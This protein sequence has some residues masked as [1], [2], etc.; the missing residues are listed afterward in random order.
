MTYFTDIEQT[1]QKF[2]WDHKWHQIASMILRKKNKV[3]EITVSDIKLY[4]KAIVTKTVCY[5]HKNTHIDQ[6]NRIGSQEIQSL[7]GQY[8]TKRAEA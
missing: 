5:W 6:W 4:Y 7:Y 8:L 2:I 1:F 3:G